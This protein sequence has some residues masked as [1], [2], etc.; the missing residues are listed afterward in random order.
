[1]KII[2]Q[3]LCVL[4]IS[5]QTAIACA[6]TQKLLGYYKNDFIQFMSNDWNE[7]SVNELFSKKQKDYSYLTKAFGKSILDTSL[8]ITDME[9]NIEEAKDTE[10]GYDFGIIVLK[11]NNE[12]KAQDIYTLIKSSEMKNLMGGK[13]F[14]GYTAQKCHDSVAI[15]YSRAVVTDKIKS[16]FSHI[17]KK[18]CHYISPEY[19]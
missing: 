4:A 19:K 12:E 7:Y 15:L 2:L 14:V 16:Y 8:A 6:D 10:G 17:N 1:M 9:I 18:A 3:I 13:V 11:Y 5:C